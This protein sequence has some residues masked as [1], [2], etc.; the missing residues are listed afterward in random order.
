MRS[1]LVDDTMLEDVA[2]NILEYVESLP[3]SVFVL[4][5]FGTDSFRIL[6]DRRHQDRSKYPYGGVLLVADSHLESRLADM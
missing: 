2:Q 4:G 5:T 1:K 3:L 6:P